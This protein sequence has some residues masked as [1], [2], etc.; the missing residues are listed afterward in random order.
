MVTFGERIQGTW[1]IKAKTTMPLSPSPSPCPPHSLPPAL[2][3]GLPPPP[4]LSLLICLS[5]GNW[6][7]TSPS[8]LHLSQTLGYGASVFPG[9]LP[10]ERSS[11]LCSHFK[12][13]EKVSDWPG[14]GHVLTMLGGGGPMAANQ[15]KS[16][17]WWG[18]GEPNKIGTQLQKKRT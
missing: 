9:L 18:T 13:P 8:R 10:E 4:P 17:D 6:I 15:I 14:L 11:F 7:N 12:I 2:P 1:R 5:P 16:H 3:A